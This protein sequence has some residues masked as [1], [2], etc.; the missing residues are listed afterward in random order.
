VRKEVLTE[1]PVILGSGP[2]ARISIPEA[3]ELEQE[4]LLL[5][6]QPEGCWLSVVAGAR[7][8]VMVGGMPFDKGIVPW[9]TTFTTGSLK[10]RV[11]G[12]A[13]APAPAPGRDMQIDKPKKKQESSPV[14]LLILLAALPVIW[15]LFM[16]GPVEEKVAVTSAKPPALF[17][18]LPGCP[19]D[20][21]PQT[22]EE[23]RVAA[24]AKNERHVFEPRDGVEAVSLYSIS[25]KCFERAGDS[26]KA[27]SVKKERERLMRR[28]EEEYKTRVLGLER[29]LKNGSARDALRESRA[30]LSL[31]GERSDR[32]S[33]WLRSL[34]KRLS[35]KLSNRKK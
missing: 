32:Y 25:E 17:G 5:S 34:E 23:S 7:T 6:A 1:D 30:L 3:P 29:H 12:G 21:L 2:T 27:Q 26:R 18:E 9:G 13:S 14:M 28:L 15:W 8:P 31:L 10:L 19:A 20:A 11:A 24:D 33:T 4:H 16:S 35:M 22:A